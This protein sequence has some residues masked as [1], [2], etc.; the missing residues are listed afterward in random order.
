[1][2]TTAYDSLKESVEQA[3]LGSLPA[4]SS[5]DEASKDVAFRT[6]SRLGVA[7]ALE[8]GEGV[9]TIEVEAG[10]GQDAALQT[11][12]LCT[13]VLIAAEG[14]PEGGDQHPVGAALAERM[15]DAA[16]QQL[17]ENCWVYTDEDI[18]NW[19]P[20][21]AVSP[22]FDRD[23]TE[24]L[25]RLTKAR[26]VWDEANTP[27]RLDMIGECLVEIMRG[28]ARGHAVPVGP[29]REIFG[30]REVRRNVRR[31]AAEDRFSLLSD[32]AFDGID[33]DPGILDGVAVHL[34]G[35]ECYLR[36][37]DF[38]DRDLDAWT[39]AATAA[40]PGS[41][42]GDTAF[43]WGA[44]LALVVSGGSVADWLRRCAEACLAGLIQEERRAA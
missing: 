22:G 28:Y 39:A 27:E 12:L 21:H 29:S 33:G 2:A 38:V 36:R 35:G 25:Q 1:M 26:R 7:R 41:G 10:L 30:D 8:R 42:E 14:G 43:A 34:V 6:L 40:G 19:T 44:G 13:A 16:L 31:A 11:F 23:E 18:V 4:W 37:T 15:S 9:S 32:S 17:L 5:L 3:G 24:E 20:L